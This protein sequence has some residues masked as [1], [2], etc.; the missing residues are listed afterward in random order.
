MSKSTKIILIIL[1]VLAAIYAIQRLTGRTS[2][3]ESKKLFTAVD[4]SK[5][6]S[7][8]IKEKATILLART[9]DGWQILTP[10]NYP[11]DE[12]AINLFLSK[13]DPSMKATIVADHLTDSYA[14]GLDSGAVNLSLRGKSGKILE[15][16]VGN[17]TPDFTG[18]YIQVKGY[19]QVFE[20][21]ENLRSVILK[22]VTEWRSKQ[23]FRFSFRDIKAGNFSIGDTLYQFVKI[24]TAWHLNKRKVSNELVENIFSQLTGLSAIDFVDSSISNDNRPLIEYSISLNNNNNVSGKVFKT[25]A[26]TILTVSTSQT[27]FV[28]SP[29]FVDS[30][31]DQLSQAL[32]S[33]NN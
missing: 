10:I 8:F 32:K 13:L 12:G 21:P 5:V 19:P 27:E 18:C 22:T 26:N 4:T 20:I 28:I 15:M 16:L 1:L 3:T 23:I 30:F 29:T 14:Y 11:A 6:D 2:T 25:S 24:D 17:S 7:I 9:S 33:K 31:K